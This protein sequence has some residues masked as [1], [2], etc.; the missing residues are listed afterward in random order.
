MPGHP[1]RWVDRLLKDESLDRG[2]S[3][4]PHIAAGSDQTT[5]VGN[6]P[7]DEQLTSLGVPNGTNDQPPAD[8]MNQDRGHVLPR[9]S[10]LRQR[11]APPD[12]WMGPSSG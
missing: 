7:M 3:G 11:V 12:R 5:S 4:E 10:R 6:G 2:P 8:S 1:P 9:R